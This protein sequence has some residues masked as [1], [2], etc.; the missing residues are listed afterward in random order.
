[1][2]A[3]TCYQKFPIR[4]MMHLKPWMSCISSLEVQALEIVL[5]ILDVLTM[6]LKTVIVIERSLG[7]VLKERVSSSRF[8]VPILSRYD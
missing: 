1:M 4:N 3:I 5:W 6:N 7:T 8:H 2:K